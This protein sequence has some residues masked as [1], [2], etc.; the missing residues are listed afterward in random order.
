MMRKVEVCTSTLSQPRAED[1][2]T[3]T[4][5][6]NLSVQTAK[7]VNLCGK[8]PRLILKFKREHGVS[9]ET[10]LTEPGRGSSQPIRKFFVEH[11]H[12]STIIVSGLSINWLTI[13]D[14]LFIFNGTQRWPR[15]MNVWL[16]DC[17]IRFWHNF[18]A[19]THRK[20]R[21]SAPFAL[22]CDTW[23][24]QVPVS[25]S[26]ATRLTRMERTGSAT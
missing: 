11:C 9:C 2:C 7:C 1:G 17:K 15:T 25:L 22:T 18:P 23:N 20:L 6:W 14:D 5:L 12:F 21:M 8:I 4:K 19:S 16:H 24:Y 26:W 13:C 10:T 3:S